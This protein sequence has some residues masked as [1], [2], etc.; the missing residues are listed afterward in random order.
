MYDITLFEGSDA[1][2]SRIGTR[3]KPESFYQFSQNLLYGLWAPGLFK[4]DTRANANLESIQLLVL[5]VDSGCT[6]DEARVHFAP[7]KHVIGTSRSHGIEKGGVVCD[8]FRVILF[9]DK[10]ATTDSE[11]KEYWFAAFERWPF[12][13]KQ[14]KDSARFF[15]PCKEIVSTNEGGA[16]FTER[17]A[18]KSTPVASTRRQASTS[19]RGRLSK[20]TREFLIEGASPGEWHGAL[21]KAAI[22]FKEQGYDIDE[23]RLKLGAITGDWDEHDDLTLTDVYENRATRYGPRALLYIDDWPVMMNEE[24]PSS[25]APENY[26]HLFKKLGMSFRFNEIDGMV[27]QGEERLSEEHFINLWITAKDYGL[28]GSKDLLDACVTHVALESSYNPV[29]DIIE[30]RQHDGTDYIGALYRTLKITEGMEG[31]YEIYLKKWLVGIVA[32]LYRPGAQ[33]LVLTL[34]GAQGIGKSRW[35]AKLGIVPQVYG[36][37][38][39]D[40][41]NKDHELRH[42]SHL[43]WHVPELDYTTSRRE[44]GAL[45]DYLTKD[46]VTVRPAFARKVR[47][48]RSMC[49]FAASVNTSEFL[50]DQ[51]GNRRFLILPLADIDHEHTVD[52]QQVFAQAK[53]LLD[54]GFEY[55][56]NLDEIA[57]LDERNKEYEVV[58]ELVKAARAVEAGQDELGLLELMEACGLERPNRADITRFGACLTR[59][60]FRKH[61]RRIDGRQSFFYC[62]RHPKRAAN[63]A[64]L[65]SSKVLDLRKGSPEGESTS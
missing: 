32:K 48:G 11:F 41:S 59:R 34:V 39:I 3:T 20:A 64:S 58:D 63:T 16:L 57:V 33:N 26:R 52:M 17:V 62:V 28:H 37:G 2:S 10:P 47:S 18:H 13:D 31:D 1:S 4:G 38:A 22:D 30:S 61:R 45:K 27:Y 23:A 6:L 60:G 29:K 46:F 15:F 7:Y 42:L 51:T 55:W 12:I 35:L 53:A 5:D 21:F 14:C 65:L 49:S 50:V 44:T 54:A 19:G 56:L 25:Q 8:R 24:Q 43:I 9:L 40:P 36:E